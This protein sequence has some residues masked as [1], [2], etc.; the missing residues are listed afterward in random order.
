MRC[1]EGEGTSSV[2]S[3]GSSREEEANLDL[4]SRREDMVF[5]SPKVELHGAWDQG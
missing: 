4:M 2:G 1:Q 3:Q 5:T